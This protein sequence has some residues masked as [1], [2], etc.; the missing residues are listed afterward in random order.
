MLN[1]QVKDAVPTSTYAFGCMET[2]GDRIRQLREAR[3]LTQQQLGAL[4]GVTKSAVSQWE[5]GSTKNLKL[6]TFLRVCEVLQTDAEY[7]IWGPDRGA[8]T[9]GVGKRV[10]KPKPAPKPPET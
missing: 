3:G 1:T 8:A 9:R 4:V 6:E 5:D 2:M 10:W 7:L